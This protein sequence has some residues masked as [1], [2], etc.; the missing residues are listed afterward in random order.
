MLKSRGN[1]VD[2]PTSTRREQ[3]RAAL[4]FKTIPALAFV[5]PY[6]EMLMRGLL[7]IDGF[8]V[9]TRRS[10]WNYRGIV[11]LYTSKGKH[12][13]VPAK[14]YNLNPDEFPR[15]AI[16]GVATVVDS[17]LLTEEE[18]IEMLCNF[19][20]VTPREAEKL[21][22]WPNVEYVAPLPFGVFLTNI[23]RFKKPIAFRPKPG[24][25][26]I[27]RVPLTTVAKNLREVGFNQES[28]VA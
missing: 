26:G 1:Y 20:R 11:L 12:H 22:Q 14:A 15:G 13:K 18:K 17:R 25:I 21:G 8:G 23:K 28:L 4:A 2:L 10:N 27:M 16:V 6:H 3:V 24:A 9:K 7:E 5:F 19:N